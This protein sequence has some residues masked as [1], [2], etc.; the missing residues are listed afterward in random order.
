MSVETRPTDN[1]TKDNLLLGM[2][3]VEFAPLSGGV[4]LPFES[5]GIVDTAELAKEL[6]SIALES[7]QSGVRV[8]VRELPTK[9]NPQ[10]N[11]GVFN[12]SADILRY[13]LGS[14]SKTAV[15]ANAA[16]AVTN[17]AVEASSDPQDFL[18]LLHRLLNAGSV[19]VTPATVTGEAVGSGD[20]TTGATS[21]D[22]ALANKV[23]LV[24]DIT[25]TIDITNAGIVTSYTPVAVG[26]AGVGLKVEVVVGTG[27]DSGN[28]QFFSGAGAVNVTGTIAATYTPSFSLTEGLPGG[29]LVAVAAALSD[30]GGAFTNETTD[31]N[32]A[33]AG[34][35]T[36]T[37]AVPVVNDAFYV[38]ATAPFDRARFNV[39]AA[40]TN[41][42]VAWEY[43]NGSAWVALS[44]VTDQ[45]NAFKTTGAA[46]DVT[47][48][49]PADWRSI[50]VNSVGPYFYVRAR[51]ATIGAPTGATGTQIWTSS[52]NDYLVDLKNG[53][54][55]LHAD[56]SK[57]AGYRPLIAG[58]SVYVDYTYNRKAHTRIQPFTQLAF[59][60]KAR[61][62]LLTDVGVNLIWEVPSAQVI[63]TDDSLEFA[64]EDFTVGTVTLKLLD[65]PTQR[66]GTME[67]YSETEA[68]A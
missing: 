43:H 33:G 52:A 26:G 55:Q 67:V 19:V 30:D 63:V 40:G 57:S 28:L 41:Y 34:D 37:P 62:R 48:D 60:G 9:I 18:D 53:R 56:A 68:A 4:F 1:T 6:E 35:V 66:F 5:L 45:T 54:I 16:Q 8:T 29:D 39:S 7:S 51:V 47:W 3:F 36:L 21:G 42:T 58:Q 59:D 46:L 12:F 20:G 14:S 64:D 50:S 24:A 22:F 10:I 25:G 44:N 11:V 32:S 27:S 49:V 23:R 17:E 65:D 38:A 31:A 2:P 13:T 15:S 61:V